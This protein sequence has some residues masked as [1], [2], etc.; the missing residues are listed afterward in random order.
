MQLCHLASG[1]LEQISL[2]RPVCVWTTERCLGWKQK[3]RCAVN[4]RIALAKKY[5]LSVQA[6]AEG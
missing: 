1:E 2:L 3:L 4:D 5:G 6:Y